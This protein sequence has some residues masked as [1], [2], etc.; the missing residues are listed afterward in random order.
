MAPILPATCPPG[1][2]DG[3]CTT[4]PQKAHYAVAVPSLLELV[5]A[6]TDLDD[7]DVAWLHRLM[8]DWQIIADLSFADLVLW[9]PDREARGFWAGGQM[10]PT[11]GPTSLPDD[12]VGTFVPGRA[13]TD[14]R[15]ELPVRAP[16][17]RG[18]SGVAR[19]RAGARRGDPRPPIGPGHRRRR[20]QHQPARRTHPQPP[21]AVLPADRGRAD[22]DD[23]RRLV[24]AGGPAQRPRGLAAGGR[25]LPASRRR[26]QGGLRQPQRP[27]G[28][29]PTRA[30]RRP[31]QP[32]AGR[33]DPRA[34]AAATAPGRGVAQRRAGRSGRPRHRDRHR[35]GGPDR[36]QHPAA[37]PRR[38]HR[39]R[40]PGAR[41]H[42]PASPRS[43]ARHQGRHHPRDPPPGEEQPADGGG[44]PAAAGAPDRQPEARPRWRRPY[45]AWARSRSCTRR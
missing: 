9:L 4:R 29:S 30:P 20:P 7:D 24:P 13:A 3:S 25:R 35:R 32:G 28:L 43:R 11:T 36:A 44:T 8:A 41:R 33:P 37:S 45:A 34:R 15:R 21:R 27:V 16:G 17:A 12:V 18:R 22:P 42:R 6:H 1:R 14:A 19:R 26:R 10:R 31:H 2:T 38:A 5:R 23:R 40:D 39:R